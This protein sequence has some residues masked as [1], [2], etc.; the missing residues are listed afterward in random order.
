MLDTGLLEPDSS[1]VFCKMLRRSADAD[2]MLTPLRCADLDRRNGS[3]KADLERIDLS[4]VEPKLRFPSR[5]LRRERTLDHQMRHAFQDNL[6][7]QPIFKAISERREIVG[8]CDRA[9]SRLLI[10]GTP[11]GPARGGRDIKCQYSYVRHRFRHAFPVRCMAFLRRTTFPKW[12]L[13]FR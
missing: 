7:K 2:K 10:A 6:W 8:K 11:A 13:L 1:F 3:G 9:K 4:P 12:V 5:L